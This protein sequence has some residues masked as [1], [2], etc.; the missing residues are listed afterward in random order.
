MKYLIPLAIIMALTISVAS[1][2][3]SPVAAW[4]C[5]ERPEEPH[6]LTSTP[7]TTLNTA[8]GTATATASNTPT[9]TNTATTTP[10]T[11]PTSTATPI[12]ITVVTERTVIVTREII[13]PNTGSAGLATW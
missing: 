4:P 6:C 12:V 7:T 9:P 10:T 1:A 5:S 2:K 8:T 13:P 3:W 11:L